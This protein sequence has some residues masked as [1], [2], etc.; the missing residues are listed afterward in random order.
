MTQSA[1][2]RRPLHLPTRPALV[3]L[4]LLGSLAA[5]CARAGAQQASTREYERIAQQLR[6]RVEA[7]KSQRLG[8]E[9]S[10]TQMDVD[11]VLRSIGPQLERAMREAGQAQMQLTSRYPTLVTN[12][13]EVRRLVRELAQVQ[14]LARLELSQRARR[15]RS[16]APTGYLGVSY[17]GA[18]R[19]LTRNGDV[20]VYHDDAPVVVS[21]EPGSPAERAGI[22]RGDTLVSYAG[23]PL[24]GQAVALGDIL[25]PGRTVAVG[26]RRGGEMRTIN[27]VVGRRP[28]AYV[29]GPQETNG[30]SYT[31]TYNSA[32]P[33]GVYTPGSP[34]PP[35]MTPNVPTVRVAPK[36]A[37]GKGGVV[38][39][40]A[41]PWTP[42]APLPRPA[43]APSAPVGG[44]VFGGT[45]IAVAGAQVVPLDDSWRDL[46]GADDD[47]VVV[48]K[49]AAGTPAAAA[50][51]R[52]G[53]VITSADG[54]P[55]LTP[56]ALQRAVQASRDRTV[57][58]GVLRK[59]QTRTVELK[60]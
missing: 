46:L 31:I 14:G 16:D 51:L 59:K 5:C 8:L 56:S 58:L 23:I 6:E 60:W 38:L 2:S 52:S 11:S 35:T 19:T 45:A 4:C 34:L 32:T 43:V 1:V 57:S 18:V 53:D 24:R 9:T 36:G 3:V 13:A 47:G 28:T 22:R 48:V 33:Y 26:L 29:V 17:S 54:N 27:V 41:P 42:V 7:L 40:P 37:T 49:V 10:E 21:I 39:A 20:V 44:W 15:L 50:G 25:K 30:Q 12:D 55:L